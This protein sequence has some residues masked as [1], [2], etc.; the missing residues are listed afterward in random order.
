MRSLVRSSVAPSL[1]LGALTAGLSPLVGCFSPPPPVYTVDTLSFSNDYT[2]S[3]DIVVQPY[4]YSEL[5]CP[6][7]KSATFYTLYRE[8]LTDA[9]PI[10]ILFHSGAFDYVVNP[11]TED[12]LHGAHYQSDS[13]LDSDW[14]NQKIFETL[15]LV[16][17]DGTEGNDGTLPAALAEAGA[18]TMIPADCWGDLWHNEYG[19]A[20]NDTSEGFT[21]N[22]RYLAWAMSAIASPDAATASYW[23]AQLGLADLP[24]TLDYSSISLVGLG[25]GG[26][27]IPELFRRSQ[28]VTTV[29]P[30]SPLLPPVRGVIIDSTMDNLYPIASNPSA[31]SGYY[32]GLQRIFPTD[33]N[34]DI[35]RYS[36][37]R[38]YSELGD[39]YP[40][41]MAWSSVDPEVPNS[42]S[43]GYLTT[44]QA[45]PGVMTDKDYGTSKHIF[46]NSN[47]A[48]ATDAVKVMLGR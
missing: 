2:T 46:I 28:T 9:A 41:H 43:D 5:L 18:F 19:S 45:Y 20:P 11:V 14:A 42:T 29:S 22:G 34:G 44:E 13:R 40:V 38:W 35:G 10:V 24:I 15:G 23:Q 39:P 17:G 4:T 30:A 37:G 12:P 31:F 16:P 7:G 33:V 36:L 48:D 21:R 26:R 8:G 27:A 47:I 3:T 25:E 32:T 6:D 1:C